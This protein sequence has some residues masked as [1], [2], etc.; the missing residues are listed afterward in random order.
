ML[1]KT[2]GRRVGMA[3]ALACLIGV[4]L[5]A[6]GT[7]SA[8]A[9]KEARTKKPAEGVR[10]LVLG[11]AR[12]PLLDELK[13]D[14]GWQ[15]TRAANAKGRGN[16]PSKY[17]AL[18]V[19]GD[20]LSPEQLGSGTLVDEFA[21]ANRW[22]L[23][24]DTDP[25]D[26]DQGLIDNTGFTVGEHNGKSAMF[27]FGRQML[28]NG[29]RVVMIEAKSLQPL[30]SE[31]QQDQQWLSQ[32]TA[33]QTQ[34]VAS[35]ATGAVSADRSTLAEEYAPPG[36]KT[37]PED[38]QH[39]GWTYKDIGSS[40]PPH[41]GY[42]TPGGAFCREHC[43]L[44]LKRW[45]HVPEP[46]KQTPNWT[47]NHYFDVYLDNA[48]RPQGNF[49]YVTYRLGGDFSPK[50]EGEKFF[51]MFEPIM[52]T[53]GYTPHDHDSQNLGTYLMERAWWTQ[54]LG[55]Q[56][57]P[58]AQTSAN[59][60]HDQSLPATPNEE[61]EYSSH[62][63]FKV[64][65][66]HSAEGQE[67]ALDYEVE[68]GEAHKI[69]DWGVENKGSGNE[70][71]WLFSAR[72]PCDLRDEVHKT[73]DCFSGFNIDDKLAGMPKQPPDLSLGQ[74]QADTVGR[75]H[76]KDLLSGENGKANFQVKTPTALADSVCT[77][78]GGWGCA[79]DAKRV[80][81]GAVGSNPQNDFWNSYGI[82]I[83]AVNPI[84]VKSIT[85]SPSQANGA[86]LDKV[87]GTVTLERPAP[88]DERVLIYSNSENATVGTPI[89]DKVSRG[90]AEIPMGKT[91]GTFEVLTNDNN[92]KP[93]DHTTATIT[94]FF[95]RPFQEQLRVESPPKGS[96]RP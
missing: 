7:Q 53:A 8:L 42:W 45:E 9:Q 62:Q 37:P 80:E 20:A 82:D 21:D 12:S 77:R 3:L 55:V 11:E 86:K 35:T 31:N 68:N 59:F 30:L 94:A 10:A 34:E 48:N 16:D 75:W 61:T 88:F 13:R 18:I 24:L 44:P 70:L 92:L 43:D 96:P 39:V 36:N 67:V 50:R 47:F 71:N 90:M 76:T 17:D 65:Y 72:Q 87:T 38:A 15:L 73:E 41:D 57:K 78:I 84:P 54:Q 95:T 51:Q 56:V 2:R 64:G 52:Y 93:G 14:Q 81:R 66:T 91:S 89:T 83:G 5:A 1:T 6:F 69:S 26:Y 32:S 4:A 46:G 33:R 58:D 60:V 74:L 29:P 40:A 19:D 23:A 79:A 22:V 28:N 63:T 85:F 49:Q 25:A 27:L